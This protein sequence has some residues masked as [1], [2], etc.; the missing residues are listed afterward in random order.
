MTGPCYYCIYRVSL[1]KINFNKIN[2]IKTIICNTLFHV[3]YKC[4][5]KIYKYPATFITYI[6]AGLILYIVDMSSHIKYNIQESFRLV[7]I[8]DGIFVIATII[9]AIAA[10]ATQSITI[11]NVLLDGLLPHHEIVLEIKPHRDPSFYRMRY[12]QF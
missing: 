11:I 5:V 6:I 3:D 1:L 9:S 7:A 12:N 4:N 8:N 2:S 10:T